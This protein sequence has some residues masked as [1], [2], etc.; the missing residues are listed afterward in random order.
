MR[1]ALALALVL[2][3]SACSS[4]TVSPLR[5]AGTDTAVIDT[6]PAQI[7]VTGDRGIGPNDIVGEI[8]YDRGVPSDAPVNDILD[9]EFGPLCYR[10]ETRPCDCP[11]GGVGSQSCV[12]ATQTWSECRCAP[13]Q[14]C[15][16]GRIR[17]CDC[18]GGGGA[19]QACLAD[20]SGFGACM[21]PAADA[22]PD[23]V[24]AGNVTDVPTDVQ[25][26]C[27]GGDKHTCGSH[28]D[29]QTQCLPHPGH[30]IWCCTLGG[31]CYAT[32]NPVCP[33]R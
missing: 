31:Q 8:P 3:L 25:V 9:V 13:A 23:V 27:T 33:A 18:P 32:T 7:D 26:M 22:G 5:D 21:C 14:V 19:L 16:P 15:E 20:G 4:E 1:L 29:C 30:S 12:L 10:E 6:G 17:N 28:N 11:D 2:V 24:D